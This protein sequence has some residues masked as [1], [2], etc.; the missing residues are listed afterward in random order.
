MNVILIYHRMA[1]RD[2][3]EVLDYYENEAGSHLAD[4]FYK[5]F[6]TVIA[7]IQTNPRHFPNLKDTRLRRG[8]LTDFPYHVIYEECTG[9]V[10]VMVI[11]HHRRNPL[12]GMRRQ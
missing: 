5:D 10:K 6:M 7:K 8:N 11:R 9:R 3:R 1:V 12:Y 2:V 4:R